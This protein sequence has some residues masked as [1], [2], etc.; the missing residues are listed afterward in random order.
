MR[1]YEH[2]TQTQIAAEI[3]L[4]QMHVSRLLKQT[5]ARLRA[6]MQGCTPD[7]SQAGTPPP[8]T[9]CRRH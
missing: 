2:M 7:A 1:F 5:L 4:S 9:S 3:G 6:A 8:A